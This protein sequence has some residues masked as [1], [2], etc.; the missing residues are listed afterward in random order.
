MKL[1]E[2]LRSQFIQ[3]FEHTIFTREDVEKFIEPHFQFDA[4]KAYREALAREAQK[5]IASYQDSRGVRD[6]FSFDMHGQMRFAFPHAA[7]DL[8]VLEKME[9][10]LTRKKA[11]LE[12]SIAKVQSRIW[13]MKNQLTLFGLVSNQVAATTQQVAVP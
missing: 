4:A 12:K 13:V 3:Q 5:L 2:Q 10:Q 6:C 11:G 1:S 8:E 7:K 9:E